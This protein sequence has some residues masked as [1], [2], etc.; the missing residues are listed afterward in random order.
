MRDRTKIIIISII[1]V[2]LLIVSITIALIIKSNQRKNESALNNVTKEN[3]NEDNSTTNDN[4]E[5][6]E[7]N[8]NDLLEEI[9]VSDDSD[10]LTMQRILTK[11]ISS[12][13]S[14]NA[15]ELI[16]CLDPSFAS[17]NNVTESNVLNLFSDDDFSYWYL[18]SMTKQKINDN[19]SEYILN[20][21]DSKAIKNPDFN[22][23]F[24]TILLKIY[25]DLKNKTFSFIPNQS[26]ETSNNI[27]SIE[28]N[29]YNQFTYVNS[30][31]ELL[32]QY[33][34]SLFKY[35]AKNNPKYA[36]EILSI[37]NT[38]SISSYEEFQSY[39]SNTNMDTEN[40]KVTRS[41]TKTNN[42][43]ILE[44]IDG[45]NNYYKFTLYTYTNFTINLDN[46]SLVPD[47]QKFS[48]VLANYSG[49]ISSTEITDF[50]NNFINSTV[51][52]IN[53]NT[54]GLSDN[55]VRKYYQ[56]H[57][58]YI[59]NMGIY[60]SEDF[61]N[62]SNQIVGMRWSKGATFMNTYVN[63]KT[64]EN[65]YIKFDLKVA[66]TVNGEIDL[67][68]CVAKSSNQS[69]RIKIETNGVNEE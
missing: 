17:S 58:D 14:K 28:R 47:E 39:I 51:S 65:G 15:R 31:D 38:N 42:S 6:Q 48:T 18:N 29:S 37:D 46:S 68:L 1:I 16:N 49:D 26:N 40:L 10:F 3:V 45:N 12:V 5:A 60:S 4:N 59:N 24:D 30:T 19:V 43:P 67:N 61:V 50:M 69:P 11:V 23:K 7:V 36:F 34:V 8:S 56:E 22:E 25:V 21:S 41:A 13:N 66:Y 52:Y 62:L 35:L 27:T 32:G 2:I 9:D 63:S 20:I 33:Y 44:I 64:E 53:T 55:K 54:K 57:Q